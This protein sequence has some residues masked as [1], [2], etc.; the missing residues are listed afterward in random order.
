MMRLYKLFKIIENRLPEITFIIFAGTL[1][2]GI[3]LL[4]WGLVQ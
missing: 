3:Y 4:K 2:Y 1:G